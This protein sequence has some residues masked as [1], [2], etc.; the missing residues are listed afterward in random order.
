MPWR[1]ANGAKAEANSSLSR[2]KSAPSISS[3]I[4]NLPLLSL[5]YWSAERMLPSCMAMN[6]EIAAIKPFL[7]GHEMRSRML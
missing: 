4:K 1:R 6:C 3:R 5:T 7:S 2:P